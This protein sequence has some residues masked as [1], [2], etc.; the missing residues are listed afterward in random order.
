MTRMGTWRWSPS[1]R[2]RL[3]WLCVTALALASFGVACKAPSPSPEV[4][5]EVEQREAFSEALIVDAG[6]QRARL[7][8]S[9]SDVLFEEGLSTLEYD[10]PFQIRKHAMRWMGQRSHVRLKRHG[11]RP[12]RLFMHGWV[13]LN[14]IKTR[15]LISAYIDGRLFSTVTVPEDGLWGMDFVVPPEA[16]RTTW[17]DL[18]IT[19]G[20]VAF[21]WADP[22][23]LKVALLNGLS[24]T[25]AP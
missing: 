10:P 22:P 12:M 4:L 8:S 25:E 19:I 24:W 3:D 21:H 11:D 23:E 6:A 2:L 1:P 20:S 7:L 15:P 5:R 16:L 13:D 17:V 14:A 9:R 18:Q